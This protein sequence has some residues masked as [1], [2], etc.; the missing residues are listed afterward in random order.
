MQTYLELLAKILRDGEVK[1]D[2]LVTSVIAVEGD[3]VVDEYVGGYSDYLRQRPLPPA[4]RSAPK[5]SRQPG[6]RR[7]RERRADK[8]SWREQRDLEALPAQIAALEAENARLEASLADPGLY[9][10]DRAAFEA[11]STR[12]AQLAHQL[13]ASEE[14]WLDLA[15]RAEDLARGA[16]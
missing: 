12:H 15:G 11:C 6:E 1:A 4:P 13:K 16:R 10:R 9:A 5:P 7:A 3:G 8:L 14:R 2:R